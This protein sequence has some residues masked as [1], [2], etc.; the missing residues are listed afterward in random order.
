VKKG[1]EGER[2]VVEKIQTKDGKHIEVEDPTKLYIA[3]SWV[4][5]GP[6]RG[7]IK[8]PRARGRMDR[9]MKPSTS[10]SLLYVDTMSGD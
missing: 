9:I 8:S 4:E 10:K 3:Q 1:E 6:W 7:F 2:K 5:R